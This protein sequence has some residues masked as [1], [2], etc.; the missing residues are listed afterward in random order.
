M[1]GGHIAK[2]TS[3]CLIFSTLLWT[4]LR[5]SLVTAPSARKGFSEQNMESWEMLQLF[6]I[7]PA[8]PEFLA[9]L[10]E[11]PNYSCFLIFQQAVYNIGPIDSKQHFCQN[12]GECYVFFPL[13]L[14]VPSAAI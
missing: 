9:G 4:L 3:F 7:R 8:A 1:C 6:G 13:A 2:W 14:S 12:R 5:K 11:V 10:M